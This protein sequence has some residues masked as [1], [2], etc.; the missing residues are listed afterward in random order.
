M[1]G[2]ETP[3]LTID[4]VTAVAVEPYRLT[5][6]VDTAVVP[7]E[8][9]VAAALQRLTGLAWLVFE[10]GLRRYTSGSRIIELR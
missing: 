4:G 9:V 8:Q 7:I 10:R 2:E 3:D 6:A 1:T 5:L